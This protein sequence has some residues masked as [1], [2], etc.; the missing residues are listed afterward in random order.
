MRVHKRYLYVRQNDDESKQPHMA[1]S[2]F[3]EISSTDDTLVIVGKFPVNLQEWN[4]DLGDR[5]VEYQGELPHEKMPG[6]YQSCDYLLYS[7]FNDACSNVLN[8]ALLCGL[9]IVDCYGMTDTGGA[10]DQLTYG[11]K[12]I[13]QMCDDYDKVFLSL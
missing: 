1:F 11:G 4:F 5:K 6:L 13:K 8:E 10:P 9:E 12:T 7:Y 2:K 3:R